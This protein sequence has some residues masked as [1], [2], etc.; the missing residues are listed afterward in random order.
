MKTLVTDQM[1]GNDDLA[2]LLEVA[3]NNRRDIDRLIAGGA[4]KP[5]AIQTMQKFI[6]ILKD[7]RKGTDS[8]Q[9]K[10]YMKAVKEMVKE[11]KQEIMDSGNRKD[12]KSIDDLKFTDKDVI[13]MVEKKAKNADHYLDMVTK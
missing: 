9:L 4:D 8:L 13:E 7:N 11:A 5:N 10:Y 2:Y 1:G 3:K 12:V 6:K